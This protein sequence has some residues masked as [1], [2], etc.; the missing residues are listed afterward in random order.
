MSIILSQLS[1]QFAQGQWLF[2]NLNFTLSNKKVGL[3][4]ANGIGKSTLL[5][6]IHQELV[7]T[8]GKISTQQTIAKLPQDFLEFQDQ[9]V[10]EVLGVKAQLQALYQIIEGK[11]TEQDYVILNE[12]WDIEE[13]LERLVTQ[14]QLNHIGLKRSFNSL[15]GGEKS[16]LL[17]AALLWKQANFILLDEPTN[18]L[19]QESRAHFYTMVKEYKQGMLVASHDR[20]LLRHMDEIIE[21]S[22]LGIQV[23]GGNYDFY[24]EQK[25]IEHAAKEHAFQA[26][27]IEL[28]KKKIQQQKMVEK[29]AKRTVRGKKKGIQTNMEKNV[30]NY[31][32][33][34]SE[35]STAKLSQLHTKQLNSTEKR[36]QEA[37]ANLAANQQIIIDLEES[38]FPR[39]KRVLQ[40]KKVNVTFEKEVN[41]WKNPIDFEVVGPER[42]ALVGA[43]G[44]GKTSLLKII[45]GTLETMIGDRYIGV[46]HI[47]FIDQHLSLLDYELTVM[48]NVRKFAALGMPEHELRICL[49]R[50]LFDQEAIFKKAKM[51]SGGERMRLGLACL[52]ATNNAPELLILDEPTNN[53][54][55]QSLEAMTNALNQF[56]GAIIVVSHDQDFLKSIQTQKHFHL[57]K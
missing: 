4:G 7:P 23:Y 26:A 27:T 20:A 34:R 47:G 57:S 1:Y 37:K 54:D 40:L 28:K 21:L 35:K 17:F 50:F 42:V 32:Q 48:E 53:M 19:D 18:H 22:S 6:L 25:E 11:G 14:T 56:K 49:A 24:K 30:M 3:V 52:L 12:N 41:L 8:S 44:S 29:Q 38:S 10:I 45:L 33:N 51:L 36:V 15:S 16:R 43:N 5:R 46:K 9:S 13:K 2:Q 31:F 55:F 39:G